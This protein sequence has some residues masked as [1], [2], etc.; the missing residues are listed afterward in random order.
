MH[1][2][3][4][5]TNTDESAF[6]QRHPGDGDK[7]RALLAPLRPDWRFT[8]YSVKDGQ[9]PAARDDI[10]GVIITGSPASVHDAA[11][12]IARLADLIRDMAARSVPMFGACFGHQAI[13]QAL[14]GRVE[15]NPQGW[16]FG[17]VKTAMDGIG[18]IRLYAAHN[19]QVTALP[20]GARTTG[21][22]SGCAIAS[23]AIGT[24]VMTTQYHPEMSPGFIAALTDELADKLPPDVTVQA[25]ASLAQPAE[26]D[27][28]AAAIVRFF[29]SADQDRAASRSIAVT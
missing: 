3:I 15:R 23:F 19:E 26:T 5:L 8:D 21:S 4:L 29:E 12:W 7:F 10:D 9:F 25:R 17:A 13:A 11:P 2:A 16:V 22:T 28:I 27:R 14:G 20:V 1:I 6:A 24:R 18:P